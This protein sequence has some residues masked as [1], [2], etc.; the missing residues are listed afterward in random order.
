MNFPNQR[1]GYLC[2][3]YGP[4]NSSKSSFLRARLSSVSHLDPSVVYI[5]HSSNQNRSEVIA[6]VK[7]KEFREETSFETISTDR[8]ENLDVSK[9]SILGVDEAQFFGPEIV[10]VVRKWLSEGKKVFL[11][12][13]KGNFL[14]QKMGYFLDLISEAEETVELSAYCKKCFLETD[15]FVKAHFTAK[16]TRRDQIIEVSK[17]LEEEQETWIPCCR[18]HYDEIMKSPSLRNSTASN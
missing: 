18:L 4:M 12:G 10:P 7:S 3:F 15:S 16:A 5:N 13:L 1:K 6:T 2:L 8:L 9:F 17:N 14:N 11:A